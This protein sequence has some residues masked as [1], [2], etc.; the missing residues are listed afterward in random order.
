MKAHVELGRPHVRKEQHS[1]LCA[2]GQSP[3]GLQP[4]LVTGELSKEEMG[5]WGSVALHCRTPKIH[6]D[7]A[8]CCM[9][10]H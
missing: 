1:N 2:R 8:L 7:H 5:G 6:Q 4:S 10:G 3:S 9:D